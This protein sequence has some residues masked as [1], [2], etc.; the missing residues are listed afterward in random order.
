MYSVPLLSQF[1]LLLL[2]PRNCPNQRYGVKASMRT[3]AVKGTVSD[4]VVDFLFKM[5]G[6]GFEFDKNK[7]HDVFGKFLHL[8]E[9]LSV[10][11]IVIASRLVVFVKILNS[12]CRFVMILDVTESC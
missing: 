9:E 7:I 2:L 4:G 6:D 8:L 1:L 3:A 10:Y 5:L 12:C 11:E